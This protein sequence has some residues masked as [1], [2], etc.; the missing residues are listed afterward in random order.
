M[1]A[2][3]SNYEGREQAY[4]KHLFL[5]DY[6]ERLVFKTA[7]KF[8]TVVYV[9]G[10]SGPWQSTGE[11]F[12]DTS[13]GIALAALRK[14][15]A[16][17][18]SHG[19]DVRM[20]AV[21]VESSH[22]AYDQLATI[23]LKYPDVEVRPLNGDFVAL[24]P[25]ILR[26]LPPQAFTFLFVDPKGWR[27]PIAALEDLL[28]RPNTEVV[29]NFMFDFINRA[30]SMAEEAIV[31]GLDE[32]MPHGDWR[33]KLRD[34]PASG[35]DNPTRRKRIL[36][37][38]FS[39]SLR[40]LGAYQYVAETPILRPLKNRTLY[41]LIYGTRKSAGIEVFRDC[42]I[43]ALRTQAEVRGTTKLA[44]TARDTGQTEMFG[45]LSDM[46]PNE[47]EAFLQSERERAGRILMDMC[48]FAPSVTKYGDVWPT[49]L[50]QCAI[51]KTELSS[52]ANDAR[53][54]GDIVFLD[55]PSSR[56]RVPEEDYRMQ[57]PF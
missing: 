30:A 8:D 55:W 1:V 45:S 50:G 28:K 31:V 36:V 49:I 18:K 57:R 23:P 51:R 7:S 13:F 53:R 33:K 46:A 24:A 12:A 40:R 29:F 26:G 11:S 41:S 16:A 20:I 38:A 2:D 21:L 6:L 48:P 52:I 44:K 56:K 34:L 5:S 17:W 25:Q 19:R 4:I 10:F 54:S 47:V 32:L 35:S 22:V 9:D 27:I 42:Q 43:D 39:E 3:I 15:R 37:E 14:A